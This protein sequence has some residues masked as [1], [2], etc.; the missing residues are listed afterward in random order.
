MEFL[1]S[2]GVSLVADIG[3][4][5]GRR[6]RDTPT[7]YNYIIVLPFGVEGVENYL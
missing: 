1:F 6:G 5:L 3:C 4:E 2:K 7:P